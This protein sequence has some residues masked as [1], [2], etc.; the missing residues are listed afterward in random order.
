MPS[1]IG[2]GNIFGTIVGD[3]GKEIQIPQNPTNEALWLI[4]KEILRIF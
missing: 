3:L 4:F 1:K 2:L